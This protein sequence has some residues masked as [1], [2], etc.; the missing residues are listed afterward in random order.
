MDYAIQ[1]NESKANKVYN[2]LLNLIMYGR[3]LDGIHVY[4]P[5]QEFIISNSETNSLY[6][7][8]KRSLFNPPMGND[9]YKYT[10]YDNEKDIL[11]YV[12]PV[13]LLYISSAFAFDI[14][15]ISQSLSG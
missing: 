9:N 10:R 12:H 2:Q 4:F 5:N 3:Y 15:L 6:K 7:H 8:S 1:L 13:Y 11:H 14:P